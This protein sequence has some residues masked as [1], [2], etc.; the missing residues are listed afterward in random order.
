MSKNYKVKIKNAVIVFCILTT[1]FV[2]PLWASENKITGLLQIRIEEKELANRGLLTTAEFNRVVEESPVPT[3]FVRTFM[4]FKERPSREE[5]RDLENL[6]ITIY[7]DSWIPPLENHPYGFM[8][9]DIP[10]HRVQDVEAL[11]YVKRIDSAEVRRFPLNNLGAS[12]VGADAL[13]TE[14]YSG[15]GVI[16]AVLDS[17][18]EYTDST[19]RHGDLPEN[20]TAIDYS[21]W[22][23]TD[24]DVRN[25][26]TGHGTHVAG[27]VLGRGI[28]S[29][30]NTGNGGGPYRGM[31]YS[32][33][34]VFIKI[35]NDSTGSASTT[36]EV[37]ALKDAAEV[38]GAH[39]INLSY[40]GWGNYNDGSEAD[41]Q[42][43]DYAYKYG[44]AV[45]ISA[46]NEADD[47]MHYSATVN[48]GGVTGCI[49]VNLSGFGPSPYV[50]MNLVWYDGALNRDLY[51]R[52]YSDS[53]CSAPLTYTEYS[54]TESP[55]GTESQWYRVPQ[56]GSYFSGSET[57]FYLK[58]YNNSTASQVFHIFLSP[59]NV[60]AAFQNPDPLYT[61]SS[62]ATSDHAI[63]VA[64]YVSRVCW[65]DYQGNTWIYSGFGSC[66]D[67]GGISAFSSRGPRVDGGAIKPNLT[68]PGQ[69]IISLMDHDIGAYSWQ[70]IDNDGQ[71][72]NGSGP[73]DYMLS[74]GTSMASPMAAGAAAALMDAY[75][76]LKGR[77]YL[78]K[79]VLQESAQ[80]V[81][82]GTNLDGYGL[83]RVDWAYGGLVENVYV[84]DFNGDGM[85]DILTFNPAGGAVV[86]ESTIDGT[87]NWNGWDNHWAAWSKDYS[88]VYVGDFN[89][90]GISDILTV[91]PSGGA[92]VRVAR[93]GTGGHF[94]AWQDHWAAWPKEYSRV[95]VG[96][97]N[98]DG[99]DDILTV[100]PTGGAVLRQS[101]VSG[102]DWTGWQDYWA[103]WPKEYSRVYVGDFNGDGKD[104]ILTVDPTGGA[105][106]RLSK[107]S[108]G[109]WSGW[110]NKW[111]AWSKDY[112][113]VYV[114]DFNGDGLDDILTVDISGGAVLR[115]STPGGTGN[116][117]GW[118]AY[119]AAWSMQYYVVVVGDFNNDALT[120]II[121]INPAGGMVLRESTSSG[122]DWAGWHNHWAAWPST[123]L[124]VYV[125]EYNGVGGEDLLTLSYSGS[126]TI[127][128]ETITSG[129]HWSGW[130][131][132]VSK[133]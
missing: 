25:Q 47:D 120:D 41:E 103:A 132:S 100:R 70:R 15:S 46:G 29:L 107:S 75:P 9:A 30:S 106:L 40:G 60:T 126:E 18:L 101:T 80:D 113:K 94:Q 66:S 27:T 11:P 99:I 74:Q 85:D 44:A 129:G 39:V 91:N 114:G 38:Y 62:P 10:L 65:T 7:E 81:V 102:T 119:W 26:V 52:F 53:F 97:F 130:Q 68:A 33:E 86:R 8:V 127:L 73:A 108:G 50:Y 128:R 13:W 71:N 22:P 63:A 72:L 76:Y 34:L 16:A 3:G 36:A 82:S 5:I 77:P 45:F 78:L 57:A 95:Y 112:S 61:V 64:S 118:Q 51:M 117:S 123:Q 12:V 35:G 83:I 115:Q 79:K 131:N 58:V 2:T 67:T 54:Q 124:L 90:D 121:T 37:Q 104:D 125:G 92:V 24:T 14:G 42:A 59:V 133:W 89:G 23:S 49:Q 111:A 88:K 1:L 19:N 122:G 116:W 56:S 31:A 98:G 28:L 109:N 87:G 20:V 48:G 43:A 4:Y 21:N 105:V 55:R 32:A 84:G 110:L 17:G 93:P 6:G 96:D 69:G